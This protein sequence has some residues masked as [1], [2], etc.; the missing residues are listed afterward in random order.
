MLPW[1][2]GIPRSGNLYTT[3]MHVHVP[4]VHDKQVEVDLF[5][6]FVC[7]VF[8]IIVF[9]TTDLLYLDFKHLR[10]QIHIQPLSSN[11]EDRVLRVALL[12]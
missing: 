1:A 11:M 7:F 10:L 3:Y 12:E 4:P 6:C 9:I 8:C 5:V 2:T